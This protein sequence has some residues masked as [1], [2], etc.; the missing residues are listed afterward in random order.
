MGQVGV[1]DAVAATDQVVDREE[2]GGEMGS[3]RSDELG[4]KTQVKPTHSL[5][6]DGRR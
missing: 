5:R 3:T 2:E 4:A 1:E 6:A